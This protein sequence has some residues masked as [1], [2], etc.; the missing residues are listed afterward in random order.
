MLD[1]KYLTGLKLI[2]SRGPSGRGSSAAT[3]PR[4][5]QSSS[6]R[7]AADYGVDV[8]AVALAALLSDIGLR[9]GAGD[10]LGAYA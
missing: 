4:P 7:S 10:V 6:P 8:P 9:V 5:S 2:D 1:R 3:P